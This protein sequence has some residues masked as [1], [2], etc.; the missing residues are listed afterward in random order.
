[1]TTLDA[2]FLARLDALLGPGGV[3]RADALAGVD[4]GY[5]PDNLAAG[6]HAPH[7]GGGLGG[8]GAVP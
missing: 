7:G 5:H 1:M 4:P 6:I 2:A 8:A 3:A